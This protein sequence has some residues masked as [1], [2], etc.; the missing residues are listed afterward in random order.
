LNEADTQPD[1]TVTLPAV[2]VALVRDDTILLVK[3]RFAPSRGLFAFPGGRVEDGESL[4]A[5]A[6]RELDEETGL[7]AGPLTPIEAVLI[8]S[9]KG[10]LAVQ[11]LLQVF[12]GHHVDGEP[13]AS[14]DA[15][16]AAFFTLAEVREL[17]LAGSVG[18]IAERLLSES[19]GARAAP[20]TASA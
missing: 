5:A 4:E 8:E 1:V 15:E 7:G 17:P 2:S 16:E 13:V 6:R 20:G 12:S 9:E 3:R 14:D 19:G 18:E 10:G 11:F